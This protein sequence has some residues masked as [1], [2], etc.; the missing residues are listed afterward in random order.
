VIVRVHPERFPL[1]TLKKPHARRIDPYRVLRRFG[2]NAYKL[3]IPRELGIN[4]VFN[5]KDLTL[6]RTPV[7]CL[8][9]FEPSSLTSARFTAVFS[10]STTDETSY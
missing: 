6:Y 8:V 3:E 4:R 1:E 2:S 9:I 10:T 5:V 7:D